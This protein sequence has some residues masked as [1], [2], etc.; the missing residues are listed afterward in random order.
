VKVQSRTF[1]RSNRWAAVVVSGFI[2]VSPALAFAKTSIRG[3]ISRVV[4]TAHLEF[5]GEKNWQYEINRIDKTH[6]VLTMP[7]F[8]EATELKLKTFSDPF[9]HSVQVSKNGIDN[10]YQV[11]FELSD[12]GVE[13]FN[14]QTDEPSRLIIDFYKKAPDVLPTA[15]E[16]EKKKAPPK[17]VASSKKAGSRKPASDEILKVDAPEEEASEPPV[18]VE[19]RFGAFDAGDSNFDRFRVKDYEIHEDAILASH[20]NI[21][22]PFPMLKLPVSRLEALIKDQPEYKIHEKDDRE[23]KEAR[24]LL[25]LAERGRINVFFKTYDYFQKKYPESEYLEILRNVTANLHLEAWKKSG[26]TDDYERAHDDYV[27]LNQHYPESPLAERNALIL[28]YMQLERGEALA[29]IQHF[30]S[31]IKKFPNSPEVPQARKAIA[32]GFLLSHKFDESLNE[33]QNVAKAYANTPD[34]YEANY[35][36]GD[37]DFAAKNFAG[38]IETYRKVLK[39]YPAQEKN[40]ANAHYNM[41]EALFWKKEYKKAVD[42]F[43]NF[44]SLFP[45]HPYGGYAMTRI[46]EI[47]GI[48]GVDSRR[49]MGAFLESSFRYPDNPGAKVARLRMLTVQMKSMRPK[50]LKKAVEEIKNA[51]NEVKLDGMDEFATLILA[52]GLQERGDYD[53]SLNTLLSYYQQHPALQYKDQFTARI[54]RDIAS[55]IKSNVD[56]GHFLNALKFKSGYEKTWLHAS[57]R[58]DV[59]YFEGRAFEQAGAWDEAEKVYGH[60][61]EEME[62]INGTIEEKE[63]RVAEFLPSRSSLLLRMA[64]V[65]VA[66]RRYVEAYQELKELDQDK[67]LSEKEQVEKV[68][69]IASVSE[70]R[71]E[72][73]KAVAALKDL[74]KRWKGEPDLLNPARVHLAE[75]ENKSGGFED[76]Q[77]NVDKVLE[78][79]DLAENLRA[80]ALEIKGDSLLGQKRTMAAIEVYQTLLEQFETKRPLGSIRYKVGQLLFDKGD[81]KGAEVAWG[82]LQGGSNEILWDLAKEKLE[83][84]K[85]QDDYKKYADRIPAMKSA[86]KS[87][88]KK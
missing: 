84:V 83:Q 78:T 9:I 15:A 47:M 42:E 38:A 59:E 44:L 28:G 12:A 82:K 27:Y 61:K 75:L 60:L 26:K 46:G 3:E 81:V 71:N 55:E 45:T 88:E 37:V 64:A 34:G 54:T 86:D 41:A 11:T 72:F 20:Q 65:A 53:T 68:Q 33:Y 40:F 24:L 63:R 87:E 30:N 79:K 13:S 7:A 32:E 57:P 77:N 14:Y 85:W 70:Y 51:I 21:Y 62:K 5:E 43:V 29:T 25:V 36:L 48:L 73:P 23:N 66:K 58:L 1:K 6:V 10:K 49:S 16:P 39:T 17:K 19:E 56:E 69:L 50:E 35:R 31:F 76:A 4:D 2:F 22:L 80:K 67:T 52:E 74:V 18:P 8:D